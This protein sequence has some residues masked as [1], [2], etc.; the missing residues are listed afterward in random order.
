MWNAY[1]MEIEL[2]VLSKMTK[3][4]DLRHDQSTNNWQTCWKLRVPNVVKIF[5][6]KALNNLLPT[7][8]NLYKKGVTKDSLCPICCLEKET[9]AHCLWEC[10]TARDV[11]GGS[12]QIFQKATCQGKEFI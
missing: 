1:H 5:L 2:C 4:G 6:W 12:S 3:C 7:K 10:S 8:N 11:R 9:I